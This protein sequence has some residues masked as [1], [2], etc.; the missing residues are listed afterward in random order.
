MVFF[1]RIRR[2]SKAAP[3]IIEF[4]PECRRHLITGRNRFV[5]CGNNLVVANVGIAGMNNP[6]D[7][8]ADNQKACRLQETGNANIS[9][10]PV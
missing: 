5:F 2:C 10:S 4:R 1:E 3:G 8:S 9:R 7:K 6:R